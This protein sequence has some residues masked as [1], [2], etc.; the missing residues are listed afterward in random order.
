MSRRWTEYEDRF[1]IA[2]FDAIGSFIGPHD[3]GRTE[4]AT[5]ARAQFLKHSGAWDAY[6]DADNV[7][8]MARKLAGR[9]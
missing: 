5:K 8:N 2:Y 6:L 3:L 1:I 7:L 9:R 4:Q